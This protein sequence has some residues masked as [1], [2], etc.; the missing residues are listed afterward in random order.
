MKKIG[1]LRKV[2]LPELRQGTKFICIVPE[3]H[4]GCQLL[5]CGDE[6]AMVKLGQPTLYVNHEGVIRG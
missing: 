6:I 4:V 5:P 3:T 1:I 2:E